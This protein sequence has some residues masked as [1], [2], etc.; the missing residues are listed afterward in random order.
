MGKRELVLIA[1]FA[2]LGIG[3]Y[4]VTAPPPPP[5]SEGFSIGGIFRNMR[6]GIRGAREVATV[7]SRQAVP[8]DPSVNALRINIPRPSDITIAGEDRSDIAAE[9][10]T[11]GRGYDPGE[12]KANA[13]A[14]KLKV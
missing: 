10:H 9:L 1:V 2:V 7:D 4:Q 14:A 5:G 11:T 12:A 3:V 13:D 6:R 8:V